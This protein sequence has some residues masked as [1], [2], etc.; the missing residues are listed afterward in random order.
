MLCAFVHPMAKCEYKCVFGKH[1]DEHY[2]KKGFP[3]KSI[4]TALLL[5]YFDNS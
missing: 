3:Q 2:Q 5:L 4:I 1:K